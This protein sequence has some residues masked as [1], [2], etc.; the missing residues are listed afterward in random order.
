MQKQE[1]IKER[2]EGG[3]SK[4]K[5]SRE[6]G[7][8]QQT[9]RKYAERNDWREGEKTIQEYNSP[10]LASCT[11]TIKEW[12]ENDKREPRKQ[13]HTIMRIYERL[14]EEHGYRGSYCTVKRYV[15][16]YK[17]QISESGILPL[18]QP[19]GHAQLDFG[20]IKYYDA[21]GAGQKGYELVISFVYSNKGYHQVFR[22]N[23]QE[24]LLEGMKK[25]FYH[26]GGVPAADKDR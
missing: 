20:E 15:N 21:A 14:C 22:S 26:I 10:K 13:R 7:L 8:S 3:E 12:L 2:Y 4:R 24:C 5:I 1:E 9:V 17:S 18:S 11:G 19:P 16:R 6:M 25:I 23:N